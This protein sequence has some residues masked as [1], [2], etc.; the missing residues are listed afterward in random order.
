MFFRDDL[1]VRE[2]GNDDAGAEV[3]KKQAANE[4]I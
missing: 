2:M 1:I 3:K 4:C